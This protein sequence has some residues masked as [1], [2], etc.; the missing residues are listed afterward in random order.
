LKRGRKQNSKLPLLLG[1]AV[2]CCGYLWFNSETTSPSQA[3]KQVRDT[4]LSL[5]EKGSLLSIAKQDEFLKD[6]ANLSEVRGLIKSEDYTTA[7]EIIQTIPLDSAPGVEARLLK[8]I[9][10]LKSDKEIS[11]EDISRSKQLINSASRQD[12][13]PSF[14]L[15]TAEF[16]QKNGET[17]A[18]SSKYLQIRRDYPSSLPSLAQ[19]RARTLN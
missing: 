9:A 13:L 10:L 1:L 18:A 2:A 15:F 5:K 11:G 16:A 8:L 4:D 7:L 19:T 17:Q 14:H 6:W 12:L 3:L